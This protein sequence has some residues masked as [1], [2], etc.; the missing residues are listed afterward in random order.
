MV[1]TRDAPPWAL[2]PRVSVQVLDGAGV[3]VLRGEESSLLRGAVLEA[4]IELVDGT[5]TSDE[6][7]EMIGRTHAPERVLFAIHQL[8]RRGVIAPGTDRAAARERAFW[9]ELGGD[10]GRRARHG[11]AVFAT[12]GVP[13]DVLEVIAQEL[14]DDAAVVHVSRDPSAFL[15]VVSDLR[16]VVAED[17]TDP[18]LERINLSGLEA[19][20]PWL[21]VRPDA[22]DVWIGP[23]FRPGTTACWECLMNRR[24]MRRRLHAVLRASDGSAL[25]VPMLSTARSAA[26]VG[27][28]VALEAAKLLRGILP[29]AVDDAPPGSAG[30]LRL[31]VADWSTSRHVVVRRPQCPAC[32]EPTLPGDPRVRPMPERARTDDGGG[33]R[34]APPEET[35][36]RFRHH[37][38]AISGAVAELEEQPTRYDGIHVW[39]AGSNLGL[40]PED[41]LTLKM[42]VRARSAGKGATREQARTGALAEALERYSSTRHGEEPVVRGS[43]RGLGDRALHPNRIMLFSEHQLDAAPRPDAG[44]FNRVPARFDEEAVIDWTPVWSL[45]DDREVLLPT[46]L[47][48]YGTA[49]AR[50]MGISSNSN[51]CAAGNT[52]TEAILQGF[53]ELVERDGV[54]MWWY[55]RVRRPAVDLGSFED[56]WIDGTVREYA[57]KGREVWAIDLTTD[58]GIPTFAALSRRA[59]GSPEAL[60]MGF[61]AH[62][63]PRIA[64]TRALGEIGQMSTTDE[65]LDDPAFLDTDEELGAWLRTATLENQPHFTP[66]PA[67]SPWR[68]EDH[69]SLVGA[70]LA[71]DVRLCRERVER[72]GMSLL[73][74]DQTR[75]DIGLPVARVFVPGL[76]PFW[77]RLAPGR[78]YDVPVQLGWLD[79]PNTPAQLNPIPFF[80]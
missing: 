36:R 24:R 3:V 33:L 61:G 25:T 31:A 75:R 68:L 27:R 10:D 73:V 41:L 17:Y 21:L 52:L 64:I 43:L 38:S 26:S 56:P 58:L 16:L 18:V 53:F 70:D 69:P 57:A 39:Y 72:A 45:T 49:G 2:D 66:D 74:L 15:A 4:V 20:V 8:H 50:E 78:L 46:A 6:I 60:L 59:A 11:V 79:R 35:Y 44:W 7:V 14:R 62:L 80:L 63:D 13:D 37:V 32:G 54:A 51:G 42:T 19:G 40:E 5:R 9:A 47:C 28:L 23:F 76:R 30:I 34:T 22:L 55:N 12:A 29:V 48:F 77:S 65:H 71:E 67:A 1:D